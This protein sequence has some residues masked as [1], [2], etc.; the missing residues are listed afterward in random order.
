MG[1]KL[2]TLQRWL[3]SRLDGGASINAGPGGVVEGISTGKG[4]VDVSTVDAKTA[5]QVL[6]LAAVRAGA[7]W[8]S[9]SYLQPS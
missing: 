1:G 5:A 8:A 4:Y 9:S 2:A 3:A 6:V 7:C